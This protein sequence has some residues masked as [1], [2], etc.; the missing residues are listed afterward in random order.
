M[1]D[2]VR[3][4]QIGIEV[5]LPVLLGKARDLAAR[6]QSGQNGVMHHLLIQYRQRAGK[7]HA[8]R[9]ALG[10]WGAPKSVLQEQKIFVFVFNSTCTSRPMTIS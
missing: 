1:A 4:G 3:L 9:T 5:V 2:L 10:I 8:H 6:G 7:A